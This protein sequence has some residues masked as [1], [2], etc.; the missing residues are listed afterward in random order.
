[1]AR[2]VKHSLLLAVLNVTCWAQ[3]SLTLAEQ[4]QGGVTT[5]GTRSC[6][7]ISTYNGIQ[8][9]GGPVMNDPQGTNVYFIWYGN[10]S[11][12]TEPA[13]LTDFINNLGGT[14]YFNINSSYY[15]F[16]RFGGGEKD[17]VVNRINFGGS[18]TD[19]YS[20]GNN[21]TDNNVAQIVGS[22]ITSG[23]GG[24]DGHMFPVDPSGVF[25]VLASKDVTEGSFCSQFCGWHSFGFAGNVPIK[26]AFIG[27]PVQC[28]L[29]V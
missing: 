3:V 25:F 23:F 20:L 1:M 24:G 7:A 8:Y 19:N 29:R 13:I 27:D 4:P 11:N 9:N 28:L 18:V 5:R 10:W 12:N 22:H 15:D 16:N 6:Q 14:A 21:L 17:P 26:V 2:F